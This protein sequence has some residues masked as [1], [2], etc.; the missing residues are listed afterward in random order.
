MSSS[1]YRVHRIMLDT[2]TGRGRA[3]SLCAKKSAR[4]S[5]EKSSELESVLEAEDSDESE[6]ELS[7]SSSILARV[8]I[9]RRRVYEKRKAY[10]SRENRYIYFRS[11]AAPTFRTGCGHGST[12]CGG[13]RTG[14]APTGCTGSA[15]GCRD[16]T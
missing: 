15:P 1:W 4:S 2:A 12:Q 9:W 3:R 10:L 8:E 16:R 6:A 13:T 5:S 7:K 14:S 11:I